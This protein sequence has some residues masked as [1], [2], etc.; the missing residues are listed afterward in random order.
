MISA[1]VHGYT[2]GIVAFHQYRDALELTQIEARSH[3]DTLEVFGDIYD[4]VS[5]SPDLANS[6]T[7]VLRNRGQNRINAIE[8]IRSIETGILQDLYDL[9]VISVNKYEKECQDLKDDAEIRKRA[10][11]FVK[12]FK[13]AIPKDNL[14]KVRVKRPSVRP[15]TKTT[16]D[17]NNT[18]NIRIG[19]KSRQ[20]EIRAAFDEIEVDSIEEARRISADAVSVIIDGIQSTRT[21][22]AKDMKSAL[23][24]LAGHPILLEQEATMQ[25]YMA[26]QRFVAKVGASKIEEVPVLASSYF[27]DNFLVDKPD[28]HDDAEC[29]DTGLNF[30]PKRGESTKEQKAICTT[31]GVVDDCLEYALSTNQKFGIWGGLS[32]R[33]LRTVRRVVKSDKS[34]PGEVRALI[35]KMRR[36]DK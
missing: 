34:T 27:M 5:S 33:Q 20:D 29:R 11:R 15:K 31:C 21:I 23:R 4:V 12:I 9:E 28:W 17:E 2:D 24:L 3:P 22:S 14:P 6:Y 19:A 16:V 32:V 26:M 25:R 36:D 1:E 7:G 10:E 13:K 30:Y 8:S 18:S 35:S